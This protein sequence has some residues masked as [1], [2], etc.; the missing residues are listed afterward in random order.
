ME[1]EKNMDKWFDHI[2]SQIHS[3]L[4]ELRVCY[5]GSQ[6]YEYLLNFSL[7]LICYPFSFI[8]IILLFFSQFF[9]IDFLFLYIDFLQSKRAHNGVTRNDKWAIKTMTF[10]WIF[11]LIIID[12]MIDYEL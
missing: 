11:V 2:I 6:R 8:I 1:D 4:F 5:H 9:L 10:W 3:L 12:S 7:L